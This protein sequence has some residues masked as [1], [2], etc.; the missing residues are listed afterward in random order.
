MAKPLILL[1]FGTIFVGYLGKDMMIGLGTNFWGN[2][3]FVLPENCNRLE[4]EY[5]PQSQKMIPLF[6]TLLGG[7]VAYLVN[8][9][10]V[11]ET[12]FMKTSWL[13]RKLYYMLNKRWLFDKLYNDFIAQKNL[14]FGYRIFFKTLDKG[15]FEILG[16]YTI[17]FLFENLT[18]YY[19]RLQS[20]MIYHYAVVML[21]GVILLISI[22]G[23][24]EFLEVFVDNRLYFIFLTYFIFYNYYSN[25][26][27]Y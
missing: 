15:C 24:W 19:S 27:S 1:A 13:P 5:I 26:D 9:G 14:D 12:Y 16:P 22:V 10:F 23:L 3:L 7:A 20:G 4:S 21:L 25:T 17:R 2:A 18:R 11:R 6:F 8:T